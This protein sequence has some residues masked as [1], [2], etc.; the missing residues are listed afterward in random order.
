MIPNLRQFK[1]LLKLGTFV[2]LLYFLTSAY[3][4]E[5]AVLQSDLNQNGIDDSD[6]TD[7]VMTINATLPA[8]EYNF[9]NLTV[10]NNA[11]LTLKGDLN[12]PED[13]K[14][15]KI[16]AENITVENGAV[17]SADRQ[18]YVYGPGAPDT[19]FGGANY[20]YGS[21]V[22]PKD[23][24]SGRGTGNNRGGGALW[25]TAD[26]I[27][28]N[29][30]ISANGDRSSSGG[31]IYVTVNDLTGSGVWQA[32]G[33]GLDVSC[34]QTCG[35]GSGGR[36]AIYFAT[37]FM[38]GTVE[39]KGGCG[40][41]DGFS[42]TCAQDGTAGFF[43]TANNNLSVDSSWKFLASDSPFTL[44]DI[45]ISDKS[46]VSM[47]SGADVT[48]QNIL[49]DGASVFTL[50]GQE[51]IHADS[52]ALKG[53]STI[54]V[55]PERTIFLE[56]PDIFIEQGSRISAN[57]KGYVRGPGTPVTENT[58]G[59]SYGGKGGGAP[60]KPV[61]GSAEAPTDFG[62]GRG[63]SIRGGGAIRIIAENNLQNDG[64][65]TAS[66]VADTATGTVN[67]LERGSGGS[68]YVTAGNLSGA[69]VFKADGGGTSWPFAGIAGGG[70]RIAIYYEDSSFSGTATA[71]AGVYCFYGCAPAAEDGTVVINASNPSCAVDCF[72]N[73]LFLPGIMGSRLYEQDG[74]SDNELWVSTSD[75]DHTRLTLDTQ[76]KS[77]NNV[78]TKNDTQRL[79]G[80][81]DE[82][83]I[84]DDVFSANIYQSFLDNLKKWKEEDKIIEDYAFI[85]YDWRLSLD[86]VITNGA[87][88]TDGNLSFTNSQ[89]FSQS[90]VLK[91]LEE[92]QA[93]SRN[94]KVIII[95]HSN[96]GLV[97]KALVQ[98]LKDTNNSLYEKIDKIIFVAVPQVGTPD[99]MTAL[100]HG[101]ELG[102]GF[103]MNADRSRQ[104]SENMPAVYNLL[105]SA[106]YF[107]TVDP[108]FAVDKLISFEN[109]PF[110][111]PQLS[112]YSFFVS[113]ENELENYI[114]G[115]DGRSEPSFNDTTHPNIG[116]SYLYEEA[117]NVHQ[118]L[119]SWQPHSDTE[120][121]QV[122]GWGEETLAGLDYKTY[123]DKNG[124]EYLSYTPRFIVDGDGTVV[125]PSALW[126]SDS[127]PNI[128]R[129]WV[130]LERYN[131]DNS[132]DRVHRNIMEILNLRTFL[133]SKI[134]DEDSST[135][136]DNIVLNDDSTLE[137]NKTRL[138][139]TLHSPLTLGITDLQGRYTGRDPITDEVREEIPNVTFRQIGDVQFISAP[140][141]I[142]YTLKLQGY[143][144]GNFSL[145]VEK[146]QGNTITEFTSFQGIP[147]SDSTVANIEVVPNFV[148][149]AAELQI[150]QNGDGLIDKTLQAT[151]GGV[152][153]YDATPPEF[154]FYYDTS[155][156]SFIFS[157]TDN[158][159]QSLNPVCGLT[160]CT[161]EDQSGNT[162]ALFFTRQ[163]DEDVHKVKMTQIAYGGT[164]T[165]L[166]K[167]VLSV[168]YEHEGGTITQLI[169]TFLQNDKK[170]VAV[171]YNPTADKSEIRLFSS[172]G[173]TVVS[174]KYTTGVT[175]INITTDKGIVKVN[176]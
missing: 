126:M 39:V 36:I 89:D 158:L 33:G 167:S 118:V 66:S 62:S 101:N 122:A 29:G 123:R 144:E 31:S 90:F 23:L 133:Q 116:N 109:K 1:V 159:D 60:A 120:V 138:H 141:D 34:S 81:G 92:L 172:D 111:N 136:P 161:A 61:Y 25:I 20:Y 84:I 44:N 113:D 99:A 56:I 52:L 104:L 11:V 146:R 58:A 8:G 140:D 162:T 32:N 47:G 165:A 71:K 6:E 169:Q 67:S 43:D 170:I 35:S 63:D 27:D 7:V 103:I 73:I 149:S 41:Y 14:G 19:P 175:T 75:T 65:I 105:P 22:Y 156:E 46:V 57:G 72:S 115:S 100:L 171:H 154:A 153:V 121:I 150:D 128:E 97:A 117:K 38:T 69:G 95:T 49:I 86:D 37:S 16:N 5:A 10:T 147:S 24:G 70:G 96:G 64:L 152:T 88:G 83:G 106:G 134:E 3:S 87:V 143:E 176:Y 68:I 155:S 82:T 42:Q 53:S 91:K 50:S 139:Y 132:P 12:S 54:T 164:I 173:K 26:S 80:D 78:Y 157:A 15:V 110:F 163:E 174:K 51:T 30:R 4:A 107:T 168:E 114:L 40:S 137:S 21:A 108:G 112:Q 79:D 142:A 129:W 130:N 166:P 13:F 2:F 135:D 98:K 94:G 17:L 18:G 145:D 74:A 85:P 160:S 45:F 125:T 28:N 59:A 48:A 119:D 148:V 127:N 131:E 55:L 151:P 76:G 77:V 124:V 9:N 102:R 93:S